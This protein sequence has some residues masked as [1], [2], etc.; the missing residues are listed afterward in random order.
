[1]QF[2]QLLHERQTDPGAFLASTACALDSMKAL[3]QA[4][5]LL[6]RDPYLVYWMVGAVCMLL[7]NAAG[8]SWDLLVQVV[9]LKHDEDRNRAA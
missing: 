1:M 3:E 5:L 2:D 6:R 7:G 9:R 4:R 8:S